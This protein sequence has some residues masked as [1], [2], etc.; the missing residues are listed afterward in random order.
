MKLS[1]IK[2]KIDNESIVGFGSA[3]ITEYENN[4]VKVEYFIFNGVTNK[5]QTKK[6]AY[7]EI[8]IPITDNITCL[9]WDKNK[10]INYYKKPCN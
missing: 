7:I 8:D 2:E 10:Y 4:T 6:Y 5:K 3:T 1:K 9:K